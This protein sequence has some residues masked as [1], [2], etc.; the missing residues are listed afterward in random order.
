AVQIPEG[1]VGMVFNRS[2]QGKVGVQIANG[3]G[4][5]DSDYR[6]NIKVLLKNTGQN[7]YEILARNTRIEQ[8]VVVPIVL[9][10]FIEHTG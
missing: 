2:S 4:I 7:A 8:L 10:K 3:T 9:P 6:G 1:F 5:I